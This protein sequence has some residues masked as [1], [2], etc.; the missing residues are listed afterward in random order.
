MKTG[1]CINKV[2]RVNVDCKQY[3]LVEISSH[4]SFDFRV[5]E[6]LFL[7]EA[8]STI[9]LSKTHC[10]PCTVCWAFK[11]G[12]LRRSEFSLH[13]QLVVATWMRKAWRGPY[14]QS[15]NERRQTQVNL[16]QCAPPHIFSLICPHGFLLSEFRPRAS[17]RVIQSSVFSWFTFSVL[18]FKIR[19]NERMRLVL[20]DDFS[21]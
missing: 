4:L 9:P 1:T 5:I 19:E 3:C 6:A 7:L 16:R 15:G 8:L 12:K 21:V 2:N 20:R 17:V 10:F 14:G 11:D 13:N 18:S